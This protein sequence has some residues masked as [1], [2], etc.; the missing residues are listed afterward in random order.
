LDNNN[1]E[2]HERSRMSQRSV[3]SRPKIINPVGVYGVRKRCL[4][5]LLVVLTIVVF[6]N[7]CLTLWLSVV[8]RLNWRGIGTISL[9]KNHLVF[10]GPTEFKD[11]LYSNKI[12][13][14]DHPLSIVSG[15]KIILQSG[16]SSSL[17]LD[18]FGINVNSD[19]FRVNDPISN[20]PLISVNSS[21]ILVF[22]NDLSFISDNKRQVE[23]PNLY[24]NS[25][26][27]RHNLS[28]SATDGCLTLSSNNDID[29][30]AQQ[31][32]DVVANDIVI[33]GHTIRLQNEHVYFEKLRY[34]ERARGDH[35]R[36]SQS[37]QVCI[38]ENGLLFAAV[39]CQRSEFDCKE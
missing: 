25:I 28:L 38:C 22:T 29:I 8:L 30:T 6:L 17:E 18:K 11:V 20:A 15:D 14:G 26:S 9:H 10:N 2:E 1:E 16:S 33:K 5:C 36:N 35:P 12:Q 21:K 19:Q 23:L 37:Y 4:Y 31:T 24:T 13:S 7:L 34:Y 32:L 27:S 39:D 3:N